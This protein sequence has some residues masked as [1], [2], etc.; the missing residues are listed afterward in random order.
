[1]HHPLLKICL[2][3]IFLKTDVNIIA[4]GNIIISDSLALH[5][6]TMEINFDYS[7]GKDQK[8]TI[9][10]YKVFV[11]HKLSRTRSKT[12]ERLLGLRE[13]TDVITTKGFTI[14]DNTSNIATVTTEEK[15]RTNTYYSNAHTDEFGRTTHDGGNFSSGKFKSTTI[16]ISIN[17]EKIETWTL[18]LT[19]HSILPVEMLMT[20]GT[21]NI[22]ILQ[23]SSDANFDYS[24]LLRYLKN[25]PAMGF[26]FLDQGRSL[27][28]IQ[29]G[30]GGENN[31]D[32][33]LYQSSEY[34]I[35]MFHDLDPRTKLLLVATISTLLLMNDE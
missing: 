27:C 21:K 34:K 31:I 14:T 20:D 11:N 9:G 32:M 6:D 2:L 28:A 1:M 22:N 10:A 29:F 30:S 23:V 25:M 17:G 3:V 19:S 15:N 18:E 5:A 16:R 33:N 35:W 4:Q 26:E 12:K 24:H 7:A 8:F 13:V